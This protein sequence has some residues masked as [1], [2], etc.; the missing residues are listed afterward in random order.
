MFWEHDLREDFADLR[1]EREFVDAQIILWIDECPDDRY[2]VVFRYSDSAGA[3]QSATAGRAFNFLFVYQIHHRGQV[4]PVLDTLGIPN[5]PA[6]N[7]ASLE[8]AD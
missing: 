6:D 3:P 7:G 4:A 5:N 2:E 8:T 1:Q